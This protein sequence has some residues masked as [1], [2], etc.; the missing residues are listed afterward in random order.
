MLHRIMRIFGSRK[1]SAKPI[2]FERKGAH[3]TESNTDDSRIADGYDAAV[4]GFDAK[5][6][7]GSF[8]ISKSDDAHQTFDEGTRD[9]TEPRSTYEEEWTGAR[10]DDE[11]VDVEQ[12]GKDLVEDIDRIADRRGDPD[13]P[14]FPTSKKRAPLASK[15]KRHP[16]REQPRV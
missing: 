12:Q 8:E 16:P 2:P 14:V 11:A 3:A 15:S 5:P 4:H 10:Q 1:K 13:Y 6:E 9:L 7:A